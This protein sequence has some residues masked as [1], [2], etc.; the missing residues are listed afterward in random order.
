MAERYENED[1]YSMYAEVLRQS[2]AFKRWFR[3]A[4]HNVE[5]LGVN[6][7]TIRYNTA[8][9]EQYFALCW[10]QL[11]A[12]VMIEQPGNIQTWEALVQSDERVSAAFGCADNRTPWELMEE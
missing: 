3:I 10:Q 12:T 9:T 1:G 7:D 6:D 8:A 5:I 2:D 11:E 4:S